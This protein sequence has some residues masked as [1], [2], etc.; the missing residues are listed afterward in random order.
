VDFSTMLSSRMSL[1]RLQSKAD[2]TAYQVY[3]AHAELEL[4]AGVPLF[5]G[6]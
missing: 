1:Q 2:V 5:S 6:E 3:K 4:L